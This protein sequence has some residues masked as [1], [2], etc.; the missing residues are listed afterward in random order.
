MEDGSRCEREK[1]EKSREKEG[2]REREKGERNTC[3]WLG[4]NYRVTGLE[5]AAEMVPHVCAC[6]HICVHASV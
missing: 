1:G 6:V 3:A 2:R 5:K 4:E